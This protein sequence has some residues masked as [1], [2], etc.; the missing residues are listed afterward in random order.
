MR[1]VQK[2]D[3]ILGS[4]GSR[5]CGRIRFSLLNANEH[6][7]NILYFVHV[8]LVAKIKYAQ[9]WEIAWQQDLTAW[10]EMKAWVVEMT[11]G[12]ESSDKPSANNCQRQSFPFCLLAVLNSRRS[13]NRHVSLYCWTLK[14]NFILK[15]N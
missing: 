2:T 5:Q 12:L 7:I 13:S 11:C 8:S 14:I 1:M 15:I 6:R 3:L 4:E 9:T 10:E